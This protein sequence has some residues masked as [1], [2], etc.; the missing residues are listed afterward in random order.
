VAR[1]RVIKKTEKLI[2]FIRI[3]QLDSYLK[4]GWK[5]LERGTEMVTVYRQS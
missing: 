5:V 3:E 2:R 1:K 4:D